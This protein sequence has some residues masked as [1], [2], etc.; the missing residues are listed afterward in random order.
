MRAA[1]GSRLSQWAKGR[2]MVE[3]KRGTP[4][5][6]S[7]RSAAPLAVALIVAL[8]ALCREPISHALQMSGFVANLDARNVSEAQRVNA[9]QVIVKSRLNVKPGERVLLI[10]QDDGKRRLVG[11]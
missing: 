10:V 3:M 4:R 5:Q 11:D 1:I 6:L 8:V 2:K 7:W 9:A